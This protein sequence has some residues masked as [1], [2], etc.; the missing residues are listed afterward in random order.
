MEEQRVGNY[1]TLMV[2]MNIR[3]VNLEDPVVSDI[4]RITCECG[5]PLL[6]RY[7]DEHLKSSK[8]FRLMAKKY[9]MGLLDHTAPPYSNQIKPLYVKT[10]F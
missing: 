8:H 7:Y 9:K 5:T 2:M 3:C 10:I 6:M 4:T 1:K